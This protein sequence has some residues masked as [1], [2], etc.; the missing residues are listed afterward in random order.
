MHNL[1]PKE[2]KAIQRKKMGCLEALLIDRMVNENAKLENECLGMAWVDYSKA[3]DSVPHGWFLESMKAPA[4][5][6]RAVGDLLGDLP[7]EED[8]NRDKE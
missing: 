8:K 6:V 2:Q 7:G 5:V 3:F 4:C 1:L